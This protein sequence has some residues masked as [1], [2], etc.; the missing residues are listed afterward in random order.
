M[1]LNA[2]LHKTVRN[3]R[4][5][6]PDDSNGASGLAPYMGLTATSLSHKV[7]PTYVNTNL[8][9]D[10]LLEVMKLTGDHSALVEMAFKLG[11]VLLEL[12]K[13]DDTA[14]TAFNGVVTTGIKEFGEC[15]QSATTA[16]SNPTPNNINA[17]RKETFDVVRS[18]MAILASVE[19][20]VK[21]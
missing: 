1:S 9:P 12:P 20:G 17:C 7:S 16:H 8:S 5:S 19:A 3:F 18:S 21:Q 11:Y 4:G 10:E 2:L 6:S 14:D 15:L 13:Q